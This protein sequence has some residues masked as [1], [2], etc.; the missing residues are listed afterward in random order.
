MEFPFSIFFLFVKDFQKKK[1]RILTAV[2]KITVFTFYSK[3]SEI[4]IQIL[5][6]CRNWLKWKS[7]KFNKPK[8]YALSK[9]KEDSL[10][11]WP[12]DLLQQPLCKTSLIESLNLWSFGLTVERNKMKADPDL[13]FIFMILGVE[14]G[15]VEC[16]Y[17]KNIFTV[18]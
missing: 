12:Y 2:Q 14:I 8:K 6:S 3:F 9:K 17:T 16:R 7:L 10:G 18:L 1:N 13:I 4:Q 11:S 5:E 15:G